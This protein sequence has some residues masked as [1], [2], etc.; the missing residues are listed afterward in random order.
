VFDNARHKQNMK[1]GPVFFR[2]VAGH[3]GKSGGH[4]GKIGREQDLFEIRHTL[5]LN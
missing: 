4:I 3:G 5:L 1:L 2:H